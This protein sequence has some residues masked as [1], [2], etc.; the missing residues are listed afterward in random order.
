[1]AHIKRQRQR[2]ADE[3]ERDIAREFLPI[4]GDRPI[5]SIQQRDVTEAIDA[6]VSRGKTAQAHNLLGTLRR[7]FSW[8]INRGSYDLQNSPCERVRPRELIGK[9]A[10]RERV[11]NDDELRAFWRATAKDKLG[12]PYGSL[13]RLLL[14]T[15]QRK[16]E[17]AEAVWPEFDRQI[18][19]A[20][21]VVHSNLWEIPKERMKSDR[22]HVVPLSAAAVEIV[23]SLPEF[24]RGTHAF[25]TTHGEKPVNGFSKAKV[26]LDALMLA[27]LRAMAA[28]RGDDPAKV[29]LQPWVIHDLRRTGR[30][31]LA[32]LPVPDLVA[33]L[34]IAHAKPGLHKTYNLHAYIAEK[35]RALELWA[36]RLRDIVEPSPAT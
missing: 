28:E 22:A 7:L 20:D 13:L 36:A 19:D 15:I 6:V 24:T 16:S 26:R 11:L 3:I 4:W 1:M 21:N 5:T 23:K 2:K 32:M 27:E 35:R 10:T 31:A 17:V 33:E 30:T 25:S 18:R 8:A 29:R 12:E 34:T 9:R 14:L